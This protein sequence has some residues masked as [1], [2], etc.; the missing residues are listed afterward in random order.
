MNIRLENGTV[1]NGDTVL[2][3]AIRYDL[4]PIPSTL[5][6]SI[7]ADEKVYAELKDGAV[8]TAWRDNDRY[9]IIKSEIASD[10]GLVGKGKEEQY[11]SITAVLESCYPLIMKRQR[12]VIKEKSTFG[13][14]Y[15][16]CGC[17]VQVKNDIQVDR[18]SCF[19]GDTAS[20]HI[21]KSMQEEAAIPVWKEGEFR[22][23][24]AVNAMQQKP[25]L[26]LPQDKTR[27]IRSGFLERH[28]IPGFMSVDASGG[29]IFGNRD[30]ARNIQFIPRKSAAILRN[31]SVALV[32]RRTLE[33]SIDATIYAGDVI[34]VDGVAHLVVT[35]VHA[36]SSSEEG[37]NY[38]SQFWLSTLGQTS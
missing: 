7:K 12:A 17:P 24:K 33:I 5:E 36:K 27:E 10:S 21:A 22:F 37:E 15:K 28:E 31:M 6:C 20:F 1:L 11:L 2:R 30:S 38:Y 3:M 34:E 32:L 18:F 14:I 29:F 35:A 9:K 8:I 23:L 16:S 26:V 19:V 25:V 13:A 4:T